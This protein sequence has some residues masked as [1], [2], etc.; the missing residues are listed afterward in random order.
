MPELRELEVHEVALVGKAA[1]KKKFLVVKSATPPVVKAEDSTE[2]VDG[3]CPSSHP[4]LVDGVCYT[5]EAG[6]AA[7]AE[8]EAA[9]AEAAEKS[10]KAASV[11]PVDVKQDPAIK[12][13]YDSL[14]KTRA[15]VAWAIA[16]FKVQKHANTVP[17]SR[18]GRFRRLTS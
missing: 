1:N 10:K 12:S 8:A 17:G 13:I 7:K 11:A 6:E 3:K 9:K 18:R 4:I 16:A 5:K 15:R 2:P 14:R